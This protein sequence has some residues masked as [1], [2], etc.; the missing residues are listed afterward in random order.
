MDRVISFSV[1]PTDKKGALQ[2]K[3]LKEHSKK[4]GI[5]FSFLV[6][7]AITNLNKELNL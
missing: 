7:R 1:A 4:T 5:S 3:K 2:I 6:L